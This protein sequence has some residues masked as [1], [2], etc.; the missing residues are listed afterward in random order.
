MCWQGQ[1]LASLFTDKIQSACKYGL[2][3]IKTGQV[4]KEKPSVNGEGTSLK[5]QI[6]QQI[7]RE[8]HLN[9][10]RQQRQHANIKSWPLCTYQK[11]GEKKNNRTYTKLPQLR[12]W[13]TRG[14]A[15]KRFLSPWDEFKNMWLS[16][17]SIAF[18]FTYPMTHLFIQENLIYFRYSGRLLQPQC[19][20]ALIDTGLTKEMCL[21]SHQHK[22]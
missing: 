12:I 19:W 18:G 1:V 14:R 13:E 3:E 22:S 15:G 8:K 10:F 21:V 16:K 4:K 11:P 6:H 7:H 17:T 5:N 2:W 9:R 20:L